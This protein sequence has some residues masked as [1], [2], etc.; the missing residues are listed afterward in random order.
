[1][2]LPIP[3]KRESQ[4]HFIPRAIKILRKEYPQKQSIA[5]A[6]EQWRNK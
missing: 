6:Y 1:M 4:K 2:P 5:I 3:R